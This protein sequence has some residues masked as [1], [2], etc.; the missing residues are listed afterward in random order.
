MESINNYIDRFGRIHDKPCIGG[1]PSSNNSWLYSAVFI[2]LGGKLDI[3][4]W[5]LDTCSL[6]R[7]RHP[8][9]SGPVISRDEILGLEYL[10]PGCTGVVQNGWG[11]S[12]WPWPKF[13]PWLLIVQ[14]FHCFDPHKP[15]TLRHRNTFWLNGFDQIYRFAFSVPW[16]DRHTILK[17]N[18]KC[19]PWWHLWHWILNRPTKNRS[20]RQLYWFKTGKDLAGVAAYYNEGHPTRAMAEAKLN[21]K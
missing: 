18:G 9:A 17:L 20:G 14:A 5:V 13:N 11:F 12:P 21:T 1:E 3:E 16:S 4:P 7:L 19:N 8:D 15:F 6:D 10:Q 2:K